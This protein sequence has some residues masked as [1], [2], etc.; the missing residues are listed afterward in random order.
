MLKLISAFIVI[1]IAT[2]AYLIT[3]NKADTPQST[4]NTHVKVAVSKTPLSTPFYVAEHLGLFTQHCG[5]VEILE[6]LGGKRSFAT[7]MSN[8]VDFATSSDSVIVYQSF[9]RD[10]FANIATFVESVNDIKIIAHSNA[11]IRSGEDLR[12]KTIGYI[13]GSA[14]DYFLSAFLGLHELQKSDVNL[15]PLS[16]EQTDQA[17]IEGKVDAI[18]TWEPYAFKAKQGLPDLTN[19]LDTKHIYSLTFNLLAKKAT[20]KNQPDKASCLLRSLSE[21][22][23][24]ISVNPK[25]AQKILKDKLNL[26]QDFIDWVWPDYLFILSLNKSLILS[27]KSQSKWQI[28]N[29]TFEKHPNPDFLSY[30]DS[31]HLRTIN[32]SA[33]R[34]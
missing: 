15:V 31:A 14:S 9:Q 23:D 8:D 19:T 3:L 21:A 29:G 18:S 26:G 7:M 10:D 17:L 20:L 22:I 27:M 32:P 6:V 2:I 34:L 12:G 33:V 5:K 24:Y 1:A 25:K 13:Q 11:Q 28:E 16:P 4:I 30:I